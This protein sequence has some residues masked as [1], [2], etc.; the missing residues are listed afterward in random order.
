MAAS[1]ATVV[2]PEKRADNTLPVLYISLLANHVLVG[3][4]LALVYPRPS[5]VG[6]VFVTIVDDIHGSTIQE[7]CE[8]AG[9]AFELVLNVLRQYVQMFVEE[10]ETAGIDHLYNNMIDFRNKRMIPLGLAPIKATFGTVVKGKE[11]EKKKD[12]YKD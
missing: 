8:T 9:E 7:L 6:T 4:H 12:L 10:E 11:P 5:T 3:R 1:S 2:A